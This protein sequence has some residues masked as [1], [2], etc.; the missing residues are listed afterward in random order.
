MAK[1][2]GVPGY[3]V[4]PVS[5]VLAEGTS[6]LLCRVFQNP[7][8]G[9]A[10]CHLAPTAWASHGPVFWGTMRNRRGENALKKCLFLLVAASDWFFSESLNLDMQP[11]LMKYACL[12]CYLLLGF[13]YV[14]AETVISLTVL[15]LSAS[16]LSLGCLN[17][18]ALCQIILQLNNKTEY[19][20]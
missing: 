20:K 7:T 5:T 1:W 15:N 13:P 11:M 12:R 17:I 9:Y 10:D 6:P 4:L 18:Q 3:D 16:F 8:C 19:D 14:C 2:T